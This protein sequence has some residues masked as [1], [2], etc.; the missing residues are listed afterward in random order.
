MSRV[1]FHPEYLFAQQ[2]TTQAYCAPK[3]PPSMNQ[4]TTGEGSGRDR[5]GAGR[6]SARLSKALN[7]GSRR[8]VQK[9]DSKLEKRG[10]KNVSEGAAGGGN[11]SN[12]YNFGKK[13][14]YP[15]PKAPPKVSDQRSSEPKVFPKHSC[16][17]WK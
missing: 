12:D 11:R 17:S 13:N 14:I 7:I 10:S 6:P 2:A 1:Q 16:V 8:F 3:Q 15:P 9:T 4:Q 5:A